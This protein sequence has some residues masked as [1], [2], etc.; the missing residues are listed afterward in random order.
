MI[1]TGWNDG[2]PNNTT[3]AGYGIRISRSDRDRHFEQHWRSVMIEFEGQ[4]TTQANLTPSFW[5][6]CTELRGRE[7]GRFLL[8][9]G[10]AP[11]PKGRPPKLRL[12]P[13]EPRRF[14][15]SRGE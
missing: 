4:A 3:G 9:H 1:V 12:E 6:R 7:I 15:L 2:S 14:R 10:L 8:D 13:T 11:W 5:R